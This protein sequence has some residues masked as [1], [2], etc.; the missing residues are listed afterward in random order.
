MEPLE[1]H[2]R[3]MAEFDQRVHRV[4]ERQW[5]L[6]TPC[7]EWDVRDLVD[8]LVTEQL[9]APHLL[10]GATLEEVGDR[11]DG[12]VLGDDPIATW[13]R[14]AGD[15]R[16]AFT[17]AGALDGTI[18]T[19]MGEIPALEYTRQMTID[20]AVHGWDLARAIGAD[21]RLDPELVAALFEVWEPRADLLADSGVFA[22]PIEV[23]PDADL[24]VRL[25]AVLG[26]D[27]R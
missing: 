8:H 9:W 3:A 23:G 22:P 27:G 19:T 24:Q 6:P 20:L 1:Q 13:E 17:A 18:H 25:L 16:E 4:G 21:E 7:T 10:A 2:A 26:R 5:D 15:A 12:D 11:F 14:A